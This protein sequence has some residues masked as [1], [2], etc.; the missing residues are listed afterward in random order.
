[1]FNYA[2]SQGVFYG[3]TK[4]AALDHPYVSIH[5]DR[6]IADSAAG[7][8]VPLGLL[9]AL[10]GSSLGARVSPGPGALVGGLLGAGL[11]GYGGYR[12]GTSIGERAHENAV[13]DILR[14]PES[15]RRAVEDGLGPGAYSRAALS[16]LLSASSGYN[17]DEDTGSALL[18]GGTSGALTLMREQE[19]LERKRRLVEALVGL[20][21][22]AV[23]VDEMLEGFR[24]AAKVVRYPKRFPS[25]ANRAG[26]AG[27]RGNYGPSVFPYQAQMIKNA[28]PELRSRIMD[29]MY[30]SPVPPGDPMEGT[31]A[32]TRGNVG[33]LHRR[34]VESL[35]RGATPGTEIPMLPRLSPEG[36]RALNA[37]T[38]NHEMRERQV[39]RRQI[40]RF[41]SHASP[42]LVAGDH[43]AMLNFTGPGADEARQYMIQTRGALSGDYA[44]FNRLLERFYG[45]R[46]AAEFS[47]GGARR[48]PKALIEDFERRYMQ[49]V[50]EHMRASLSRRGR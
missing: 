46:A 6:T 33:D 22:V 39:P 32:W 45:P 48:I 14:N 44:E 13:A 11:A 17:S 5:R 41:S 31:I 3:K 21:K 18:R 10:G 9:G 50:H 4:I 43:N 8:A 26:V 12:L 23:S 2:T 15:A 36:N 24:S 1:M 42:R 19:A 47:A 25:R 30:A 35:N 29:A 20:E 16:G 49:L 34:M 7:M 28:P 38:A 27:G 37:F 40:G